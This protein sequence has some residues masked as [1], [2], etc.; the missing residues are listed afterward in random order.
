MKLF[1]TATNKRFFALA[2]MPLF[3][4]ACGFLRSKGMAIDLESEHLAQDGLM[5]YVF[6][7]HA[8]EALTARAKPEEVKP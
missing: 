4:I 5:L 3:P 7:S 8:R 1:S 2:L 6:G